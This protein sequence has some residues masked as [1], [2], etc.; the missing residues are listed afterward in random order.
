MLFP[1]PRHGRPVVQASKHF[2]SSI[3][4]SEDCAWH[5]K[6]EAADLRLQKTLGL[7]T[8]LSESVSYKVAKASLT[9]RR[10]S[11]QP[12]GPVK[13]L[14]CSSLSCCPAYRDCEES[15]EVRRISYNWLLRALM[16]GAFEM[17]TRPFFLWGNEL[18]TGVA[19]ASKLI[20]FI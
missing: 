13:R 1:S 5:M 2:A 12:S 15:P 19:N 7:L 6:M 8:S 4:V 14:N 16:S 11:K 10:R 9:R 20:D 3:T 17:R 18:C